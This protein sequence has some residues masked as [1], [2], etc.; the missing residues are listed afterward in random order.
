[1]LTKE[2]IGENIVIAE[3]KTDSCISNAEGK[4][5]ERDLAVAFTEALQ[6]Q[7]EKRKFSVGSGGKVVIEGELTKVDIGNRFIRYITLSFSGKVH[8]AFKGKVMQ[9]GN[10]L[11]EF[12]I[13]VPHTSMSWIHTPR[14]LCT[15]AAKGCALKL[16]KMFEK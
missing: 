16:A 8:V 3:I 10:V 6:K 2:A 12:D 1:M 15:Q 7:L 9:D 13:E 4:F 5:N 14:F 11:R